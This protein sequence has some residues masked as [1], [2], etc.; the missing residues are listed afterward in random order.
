MAAISGFCSALCPPVT[1]RWTMN[2]PQ[3]FIEQNFLHKTSVLSEIKPSALVL[4]WS[5]A[6]RALQTQTSV[7]SYSQSSMSLVSHGA[8]A[9]V[10]CHVDSACL[11]CLSSRGLLAAGCHRLSDS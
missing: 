8:P 5:R 6:G 9:Q 7:Q 4:N 1:T 2:S 3:L 11:H 10:K